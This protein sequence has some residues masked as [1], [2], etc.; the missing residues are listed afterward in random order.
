MGILTNNTYIPPVDFQ[1]TVKD[2][3]SIFDFYDSF[4]SNISMRAPFALIDQQLFGENQLIF[5]GSTIFVSYGKGLSKEEIQTNNEYLQKFGYIRDQYG[6]ENFQTIADQ[7]E[8][9]LNDI[10]I[11]ML[12]IVLSAAVVVLAGLIGS[13]AISTVRQKKH[14]GIFFLCGCRWK[15]CT[16]IILAYLT[17][18]FAMAAALT[19]L[20]IIVMKIL[21]MDY[22]IGSV[23]SFNNLLV[24][25]FEIVV[26][27]LLAI[28]LP[29]SIIKNSSPVETIK[30]N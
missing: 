16:K 29:H 19:I 20:G 14:F 26:M 27:Y 12:P 13:I 6:E 18:L 4:D 30:E 25:I 28:I 3:M 17:I 23:Y 8:K 9:Y 5:A 10:Y 22:L 24:S 15:D 7:S 21:N 11:H 1:N 2:K